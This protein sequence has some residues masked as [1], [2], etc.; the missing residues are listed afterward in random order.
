MGALPYYLHRLDKVAGAAHFDIPDARAQTLIEQ[1]KNRMP[2]Y[3][4]PRLVIR[5]T[6]FRIK[7]GVN[8][9]VGG[10]LKLGDMYDV[11]C[12]T[13]S[14]WLWGV[15]LRKHNVGAPSRRS[16]TPGLRGKLRESRRD[17]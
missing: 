14:R 8:R 17:A 3:L 2:G 11:Q 6:R 1:M 16:K 15:H 5:D 13:N 9:L 7:A 4:V 12:P 10:Q